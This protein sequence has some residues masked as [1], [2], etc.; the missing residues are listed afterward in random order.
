MATLTRDFRVRTVERKLG[1]A[2]VLECRIQPFGHLMT[3]FAFGPVKT[4]VLVIFD[5]A[6]IALSWSLLLQLIAL[7]TVLAQ[8]FRVTVEQPEFR[9]RKVIEEILGPDLRRVAI[10]ALRPVRAQM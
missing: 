2:R 3:S 1:V 4:V 8:Q 6:V 7:V 10:L 5:M 9:S